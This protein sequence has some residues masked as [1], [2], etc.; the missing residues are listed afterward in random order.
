MATEPN[1]ELLADEMVPR[2]TI[3]GM[4][5]PVPRMAIE[6]NARITP[7]LYRRLDVLNDFAMGKVSLAELSPDVTLDFATA[8]Y[9]GLTRGH[10][11]LTRAEFDDMPIEALEVLLAIHVIGRQTGM[12][13]A[14]KSASNGVARPLVVTAAET[15]PTGNL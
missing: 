7:I 12:L 9:F 14:D 1:K 2:I 6:Q 10:K 15:L 5:W 13:K 3:A 11:G 4:E 8:V